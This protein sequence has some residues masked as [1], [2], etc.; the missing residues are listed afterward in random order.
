MIAIRDYGSYCTNIGRCAPGHRA[1]PEDIAAWKDVLEGRAGQATLAPYFADPNLEVPS[2]L[3]RSH[4][5]ALARLPRRLRA[6][7]ARML[8][9]MV[10]SRGFLAGVWGQTIVDRL[11]R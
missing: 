3:T 7:A 8:R 2:L 10:R 11:R 9:R 5:A 1:P 6:L 4:S